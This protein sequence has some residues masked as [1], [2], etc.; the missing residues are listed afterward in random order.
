MNCYIVH[1]IFMAKKFDFLKFELP[2]YY[3]VCSYL[4]N[5]QLLSY[6]KTLWHKIA[7]Q[8]KQATHVYVFIVTL[9]RP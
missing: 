9:L 6:F 7:F 2:K 5:L 3:K 8:R 1:F 4:K